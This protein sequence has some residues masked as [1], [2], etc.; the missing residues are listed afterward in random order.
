MPPHV[1]MVTRSDASRP[2]SELTTCNDGTHCQETR[3]DRATQDE[4][5]EF[6]E[7]GQER[8][9]SDQLRRQHQNCHLS[10]SA[11][12][13]PHPPLQYANH[14]LSLETQYSKCGRRNRSQR[15]SQQRYEIRDC[16]C[17]ANLSD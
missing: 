4:C 1:V 2:L 5:E 11:N 9:L 14:E 12:D 13:G 10:N 16:V 8:E 15:Q 6:I 3:T 7:F 17:R